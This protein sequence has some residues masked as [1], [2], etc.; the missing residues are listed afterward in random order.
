MKDAFNTTDAPLLWNVEGTRAYNTFEDIVRDASHLEHFHS[1]HLPAGAK[2][3]SQDDIL[4]IDMH[5]DQG[6]F[7]V[8]V[9]ALIVEENLDHQSP[10]A[11]VLEGAH[12]GE[13]YLT[14]PDG[15]I[16]SVDFGDGDELVIMLGD[17]VDQ[18]FNG[19]SDVTALRAAPHAMAM[20]E[21]STSTQSRVWYGRM[22]LPPDEALNERTGL[23]F[24]RF[25]CLECP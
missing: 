11:S 3:T 18:Y 4:S 17:G 16:V 10:S 15:E 24:A 5:A 20:P 21:S 2:S 1:Y 25:A 7:I 6:L 19:K 14:L 8:F 13:F 22:F 23:S 9:P 12:A